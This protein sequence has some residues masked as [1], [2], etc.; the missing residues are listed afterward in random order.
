MARVNFEEQWWSDPRRSALIKRVG[1]EERAD[2]VMAKAWRTAQEF[3]KHGGA[4]VPNSIFSVLAFASDIL[5][6]GLAEQR[7]DGVYLRG[8]SQY[9]SWIA[10]RRAAAKAGG[11]KSAAK[12]VKKPKQTEANSNQTE[13][14]A[15]QTQA[16]VS[17]SLSVSVSGSSS[18]S[19][20]I[21][22]TAGENSPTV[23]SPVGF[24]IGRY[25][26]AYQGRYGEKARPD[27]RGKIQGE[28]KRF[29]EETP[30]DR[31]CALIETYLAMG[32]GWFIT[33][34]HDFTTFTGNVTK[35]GLLLDTGQVSK[36]THQQT[37]AEQISNHNQGLHDKV[38]RGEL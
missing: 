32:D 16:S 9:L 21:P 29:V 3:W 13:A 25:V 6:V 30:L 12:R 14:S 4:V 10:E 11:K 1:E 26:K 8:S 7:E 17:G 20:E 24:F 15:N 27:L 19:G 28:I 22:P 2:G 5:A 34:G 35:V 18:D 38:M 37:R 23:A 31:A 36:P 33:K